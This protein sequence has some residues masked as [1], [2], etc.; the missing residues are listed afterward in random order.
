MPQ[1]LC[2]EFFNVYYKCT[3][4]ICV[5]W[6]DSQWLRALAKSFAYFTKILFGLEGCYNAR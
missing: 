1:L 3:C 6:S 2:L 4:L 5:E